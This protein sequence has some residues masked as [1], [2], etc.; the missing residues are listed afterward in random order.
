[1]LNVGKLNLK[2]GPADYRIPYR[3]TVL[4]VA[5]PATRLGVLEVS[6]DPD[7]RS[8]MLKLLGREYK[9]LTLDFATGSR[10]KGCFVVTD[11]TLSQEYWRTPEQ[12]M[13]YGSNLLTTCAE[14]PFKANLTVLVVEDGRY[15]TGDC[16]GKVR[17]DLLPLFGSHSE[18]IQFRMIAGKW[19]AKGTVAPGEQ[20]QAADVIL[21]LSAFKSAAKP[22]LGTH[23]MNVVWGSVFFSKRRRTRVSYQF[24]QWFSFEA[25]MADCREHI[26]AET[27]RLVEASKSPKAM[28]DLMSPTTDAEFTFLNV[29]KADVHDQLRSHLW[30]VN[31]LARMLR[32]RW[33]HLATGAGLF[34]KGLMGMPDE[35]L[36]DGVVASADLKE[37]PV[38]AFRYPVRSWADI[39]LLEVR[40]DESLPPG[41]AWMNTR[42][43]AAMAGD[44]DGDYFNFLS[45][46]QYPTM[47]SEVR[48]WHLTRD[49]PVIPKATKRKASG[50]EDF[51]RV[52]YDSMACPLGWVTNLITRAVAAGESDAADSLAA[53]SQIS[54]D[55]LKW[56]VTPNWKM[57]R[58]MHKRLPRLP[59]LEQLKDREVFLSKPMGGAADTIGRLIAHTAPSW[60]PP[61]LLARPLEEFA[62]LVPKCNSPKLRAYAAQAY[63]QYAQRVSGIMEIEDGDERVAELSALIRSVKAWADSLNQPE[64]VFK[65]LWQLA[66]RKR[67]DDQA[68][69]TGS[70][71]FHAFEGLA[72]D[73]LRSPAAAPEV[74][75]VVGLKHHG[76]R[77]GL[78]QLKGTV[79]KL[80][81]EET[82]LKGQ[83]RSLAYLAG[84]ALG[85]VSSE[86]PTMPGIYE[87]RLLWNGAGAV[88]ASQP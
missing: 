8:T 27:A 68:P 71:V 11:S 53:Q 46:S 47:A 44:F 70:I 73:R 78:S 42:T 72:C 18:A 12:A 51:T 56:D 76:W 45:A 23:S 52:A 16:H 84:K 66:H 85:I 38:I 65:A 62:Y 64:E 4:E 1:M 82:V 36:P 75:T 60:Q 61:Q 50:W 24:L 17:P 5:H 9:G 74:V 88:Y 57:L 29:I 69:S 19:L 59:W 37:G 43:A 48:S 6:R 87:R 30:V 3:N 86:T 15:K 77:D 14:Q 40:F 63:R 81:V 28:V 26:E 10:K 32:Q 79:D 41:T 67:S 21:P 55:M 80:V 13:A 39:R 49:V 83:I 35:D 7:D 33:L 34:A 31:G 20:G 2:T 25:V 54:V 22:P 58:V